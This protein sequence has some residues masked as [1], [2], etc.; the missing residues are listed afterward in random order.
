LKPIISFLKFSLYVTL[1]SLLMVLALQMY[2]RVADTAQEQQNSLAAVQSEYRNSDSALLDGEVVSAA[3]A[4]SIARKYKTSLGLTKNGVMLDPG[5]TL[6]RGLFSANTKWLVTVK[7]N[8]NGVAYEIDFSDVSLQDT[9]PSSLSEAKAS[10][11][12]LVGCNAGEG[13]NDIFNRLGDINRN[14][15]YREKLAVLVGADTRSDWDDVYSLVDKALATYEGS[16][17]HACEQFTIPIN[18]S[19]V[20]EMDSPSFCYLEGYNSYGMIVFNGGSVQVLGD[21]D[22]DFVHVDVANK[23]IKIENVQWSTECTLIR[24]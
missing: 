17:I 24:K 18:S 6:S 2:R 3:K 4:V 15:E 9:D 8:E 23:T 10:I 19:H 20:W 14:D 5:V 1:A 11:A 16:T 21:Y 7:T 12:A 22:S 13:W